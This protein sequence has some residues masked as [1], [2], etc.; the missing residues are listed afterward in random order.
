MSN[1]IIPPG[2]A[3]GCLPRASKVGAWCPKASDRIEVIPESQVMERIEILQQTKRNL[4][5]QIAKIGGAYNQDGVGSCAC[6]AGEGAFK[7]LRAAEGQPF[8]Q[9]NPWALY[10][11]T[12]H[13]DTGRSIDSILKAL[14]TEGAIPEELF[15]RY[16]DRGRVINGWK[17]APPERLYDTEAPRFRIHEWWD[18]E[19]WEEIR[20]C[21]L[22]TPPKPVVFGHDNHAEV[23]FEAL[24]RDNFAVLGSWGDYRYPRPFEDVPG[25]HVMH[26]REIEWKFGAFS[27]VSAVDAWDV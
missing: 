23:A 1:F 18:V 10:L 12:G 21:L 26:R 11:R 19:R 24:D 2:M 7:L 8:V 22:G 13:R 17:D 25:C 5:H 3:T 9:F 27:P 20:T 15:P 16:D 4:R 14:E 6:E